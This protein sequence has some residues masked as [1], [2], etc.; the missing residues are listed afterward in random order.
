MRHP[1]EVL[2]LPRGAAQEGAVAFQ[3]AVRAIMCDRI[4]VR[5][6]NEEVIGGLA[7]LLLITGLLRTSLPNVRSRFRTL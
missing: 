1:D 3:S 7:A 5:D 2:Y 4:K 6:L